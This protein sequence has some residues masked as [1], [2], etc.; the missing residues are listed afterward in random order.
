[1]PADFVTSNGT[2]TIRFLWPG[3]DT[4]KAQSIIDY[5]ALYDYRRGLGPTIIG[6]EGEEIR[7]PWADLTNQEKLDMAFDAATRLVAAQARGSYVTGQVTD[8]RDVAVA[9][10]ESNLTL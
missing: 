5:A 4:A 9:Y 2:V 6:P 8:A 10:A 1:M 3:I 7:K